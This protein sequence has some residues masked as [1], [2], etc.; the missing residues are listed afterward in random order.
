[1]RLIVHPTQLYTAPPGSCEN[2][3]DAVRSCESLSVMPGDTVKA[4]V[5]AKYL[6]TNSSNWTTALN[7]LITSIAN[8]TAPA[9][10][11]VDGG[12]T[13]STGGIT[14]P[15]LGLLDKSSETG[16]APKAYLNYLIFDRDYNMLDGG[17]VRITDAAR[18]YGQ[19]GAHERLASQFVITQPGYVYIYLSNDNAASGG[20]QVEVYFDDFKVEQAKS[21]V[22]Q[23]DDYYPFGLAFNSYSRENSVPNRWKFQSQEHVDD[24]GLNWDA[25]KWRNHQPDIGRFFNI[26][27]LSEKYYYNSPYAFSE[28]KVIAH[29]ELEGLESVGVNP[30]GHPWGYLVEGFRRYFDGA[31]SLFS[32]EAKAY[33][34]VSQTNG[35]TSG[36]VSVSTTT[37]TETK[38]FVKVDLSGVMDANSNNEFVP[39]S[40]MVETGVKTSTSQTTE[41]KAT[42]VTP[43]G[44]PVNVSASNTLNATDQTSTNK[45]EV[46]VGVNQGSV[47]GKVYVSNST[48]TQTNGTTDNKTSMGAKVETPVYND[49]KRKVSVGI[50]AEI[51][52]KS[53]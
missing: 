38:A 4:E 15:Y 48:T 43:T 12:A 9:G 24:L 19:D 20:Q 52:H 23:M 46:S 42:V 47:Q 1:M 37:S 31:L 26:D 35:T 28:N 39:P 30:S 13:G 29:R 36:T 2:E 14:A 21:S 45:V 40:N 49:G 5:Y 33:T 16:T 7:N 32:G 50:Q 34:N 6:D 25:F 17:F 10:T 22:V 51:T 3:C 8:G 41:V 18:E 27:P 44:V 11:F 53:N